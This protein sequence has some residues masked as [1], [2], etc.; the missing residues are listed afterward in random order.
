MSHLRGYSYQMLIP[1][2]LLDPD[3]YTLVEDEIKFMPN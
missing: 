1:D 3:E 2:F